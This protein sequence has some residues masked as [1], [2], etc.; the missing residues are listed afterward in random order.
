M[1]DDSCVLGV[2]YGRDPPLLFSGN[3][4]ER[5]WRMEM[6]QSPCSQTHKFIVKCDRIIC[7]LGHPVSSEFLIS[8]NVRSWISLDSK[9]EICSDRLCDSGSCGFWGSYAWIT[10]RSRSWQ[11]AAIVRWTGIDW[12]IHRGRW[13]YSS[14]RL[15]YNQQQRTSATRI[16]VSTDTGRNPRQTSWPI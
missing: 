14:L 6:E 5:I 15:H 7:P 2:F 9:R 8:L 4:Y 12:F 1:Q 16:P 3:G 13:E 11:R 10:H